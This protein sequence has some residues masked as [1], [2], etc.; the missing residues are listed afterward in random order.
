M[1]RPIPR[2]MFFLADS[3][4]VPLTDIWDD[5][6]LISSSSA[7]TL[8]SSIEKPVA[9]LE[10]IISACS[11]KGNLVLDAFC[12]GGTMNWPGC[13]SVRKIRVEQLECPGTGPTYRR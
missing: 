6:A 7:Q 11:T 3:P 1:R 12:G 2:L 5:I 8:G 9:P 4:G 13:C 10:R